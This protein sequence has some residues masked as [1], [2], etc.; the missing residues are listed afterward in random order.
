LNKVLGLG[1]DCIG[2]ND[3]SFGDGEIYDGGFTEIYDITEES[4]LLVRRGNQVERCIKNHTPV[5]APRDSD[6]DEEVGF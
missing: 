3:F 6:S 1:A 5:L 4:R 2:I